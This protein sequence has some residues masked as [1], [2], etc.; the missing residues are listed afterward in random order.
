MNNAIK[1]KA[2]F[3]LTAFIGSSYALAAGGSANLNST[4]AS[5]ADGNAIYVAKCSTCHG[6]DGSG[7]PNWRSKGQPDFTDAKWQKSR[8]D[9]QIAES[10]KNGKGKYMPAFKAKLSDAE[11]TAVVARIRSFAKK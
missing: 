10:T 5:V 6:K 7:I 2:L 3:L 1:L 8:T 11:I 9:A 4:T